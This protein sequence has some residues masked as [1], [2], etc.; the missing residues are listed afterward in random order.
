[1]GNFD[2]VVDGAK[3]SRILTHQP[4]NQNCTSNLNP[5]NILAIIVTFNPNPERLAIVLSSLSRQV[6][7]I[8]AVDN[9]STNAD[10]IAALVATHSNATLIAL[11]RNLGIGAA[12][13]HGVKEARSGGCDAVLL[14]DQDSTPSAN[15]VS[16]LSRGLL[17]LYARGEKVAAIGPRFIDRKSGSMSQHVV[18][19]GWRVGRIDCHAPELPVEVDFLITS[20]SLIP[21][22]ALNTVGLF[23]ERLFIDHVDTEW[24]L[25]AQTKGYRVF[26]DCTAVMEHD[27]GEWRRRIWLGRWR[28]VPIH[29]PFR[30]YYIFRNS[31]WL[32]QQPQASA[33]WK[34]V[35]ATRLMQIFGFIA[36][37]HPQRL[38]VIRMILRG[39][40]DGLRGNMG[41]GFNH[42]VQRG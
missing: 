5:R 28:E 4:V 17:H 2:L 32:R 22:D 38:T 27:L 26:G 12:L 1:L 42:E 39:L 20:G 37:F 18:F 36:L 19:A 30:Y 24:V 31:I 10:E 15:M 35:D 11:G 23:D 13:N 25:R 34:R 9:G 16:D 6:N 14:M 41:G 21:L 33:E 29:K 3:C 8:V 40:C 7:R